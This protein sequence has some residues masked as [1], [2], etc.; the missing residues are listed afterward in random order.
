MHLSEVGGAHPVGGE[1]PGQRGG[2]GGG[3]PGAQP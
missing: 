2:G 3:K 1:G